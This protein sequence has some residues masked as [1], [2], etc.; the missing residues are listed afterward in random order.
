[1][2]E[3]TLT[4][5]QVRQVGLLARLELGEEEV[6]RLT[7]DLNTMLAHFQKLNELDTS[8]VEPTFHV[9]DLS[10]V[11]RDDV[12]TPS[13]PADVV[14]ANA[15]RSEGPFFVVPRIVETD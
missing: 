11:M 8:A 10:N 7:S 14:V 6:E 12:L 9:L 13:L 5:D 1:M 2:E 15:P 4:R 3:N